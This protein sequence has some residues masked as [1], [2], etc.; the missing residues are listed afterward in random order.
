MVSV[1][2]PTAEVNA[3]DLTEFNRSAC[4]TFASGPR[5][6]SQ[7]AREKVTMVRKTRTPANAVKTAKREDRFILCLGREKYG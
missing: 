3:A 7:P 2:L 1:S 5:I 6:T 4:E